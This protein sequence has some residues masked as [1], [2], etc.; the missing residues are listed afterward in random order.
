[1][2][3]DNFRKRCRRSHSAKAHLKT[4]RPRKTKGQ[5]NSQEDPLLDPFPIGRGEGGRRSDWTERCS[6]NGWG[7][8]PPRLLSGAPRV[9]HGGVGTQ[10]AVD[11]FLRLRWTAKTKGQVNSQTAKTKGQVNSQEDLGLT[12][13]TPRMRWRTSQSIPMATSRARLRMTRSSRTFS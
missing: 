2:L 6:G 1:L 10:Q 4:P 8:Q 13:S 9:G 7:S 3:W 5:V 11:R 12:S